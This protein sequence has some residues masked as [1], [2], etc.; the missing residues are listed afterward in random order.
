MIAE[1]VTAE[2]DMM[3][4]RHATPAE[5]ASPVEFTVD[6]PVGS[7]DAGR[8][9]EDAAAGRIR[10]EW[11][12]LADDG[13][14]IVA[15]ALW[16]GRSDSE[17]PLAL[18][19]L[20]V[21][22]EVPGRVALA[23]ELLSRGH[24]EFGATPEF[25]LMLRP[26]WRDDPAVT[27]AVAWRADAARAAGLTDPI[28]RL[29]YEWTPA[30][31][32]PAPPGR[33]VFRPGEDEEFLAVFRRVAVGS[34]DVSTQRDLAAMDADRQARGDLAFYRSCPG[35]RSWWLLAETADGE[36]AGFAI[37]S[38]TPYH[39]NVGYLGVVPELRGRGYVDDLL[40]EITRIHAADGADRITATTDVPNTPMAAAFDRANYQV[41]QVRMI[42]Q[43]ASG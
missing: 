22:P 12:W 8:F 4:I 41:T 40:G 14:R 20:H 5:M 33:L 7:V 18:D 16:W 27:A 42:F 17:R 1:P 25:N 13:S 39:R 43:P 30:A 36:L 24:A 11:T 31:G 10:P 35:E 32:V 23:A 38:A 3:L 34:L 19:C 26:G 29:R 9:R 28:E 37:P 21:L 6:D 2:G 15:R